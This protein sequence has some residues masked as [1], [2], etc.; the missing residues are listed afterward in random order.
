[1][2][3]Q[4]ITN[5]E[6]DKLKGYIDKEVLVETVHISYDFSEGYGG[7]KI[8]CSGRHIHS[9]GPRC[10]RKVENDEIVIDDM[11]IPSTII[12]GEHIPYMSESRY[13]GSVFLGGTNAETYNLEMIT[14]IEFGDK[15]MP[16]SNFV[17]FQKSPEDYMPNDIKEKCETYKSV[18][19][20][21]SV[22]SDD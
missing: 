8:F 1:M 3:N 9:R 13:G 12:D 16:L 11:G 14:K 6:L 4:R 10:L 20:P 2:T 19:L 7:N 21:P 15:S 5:E 22:D 17:V 18:P